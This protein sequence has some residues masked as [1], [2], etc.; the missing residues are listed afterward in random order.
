MGCRDS[1]KVSS[2]SSRAKSLSNTFPTKA[3]TPWRSVRLLLTLRVPRVLAPPEKQSAAP[4]RRI[5]C[6][7]SPV[8]P[9]MQP[10]ALG[11]RRCQ[12]WAS[13]PGHPNTDT[14][15]ETLSFQPQRQARRAVLVAVLVALFILFIAPAAIGIYGTK[16]QFARAKDILPI[17][18]SL[19]TPLLMAIIAVYLP[20]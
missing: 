10:L 13:T 19:M 17:V 7:L 6:V 4:R 3:K 1:R 16:E 12:L 9:R 8:L 11:D 20:K 18:V 2:P 14:S 5:P 15:H